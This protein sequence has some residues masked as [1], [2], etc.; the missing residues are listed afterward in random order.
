MTLIQLKPKAMMNIGSIA[1]NQMPGTTNPSSG[2]TTMSLNVT[3]DV[4][5][6]FHVMVSSRLQFMLISLR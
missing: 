1:H 2:R 4:S 3:Q 5:S 6:I